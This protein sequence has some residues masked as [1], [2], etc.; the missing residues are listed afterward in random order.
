MTAGI[1]S[2]LDS[3]PHMPAGSAGVTAGSAT[4]AWQASIGNVAAGSLFALLQSFG[5]AGI[6]AAV[7]AV[8]G[9]GAGGLTAAGM[10]AHH[11]VQQGRRG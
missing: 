3:C 9:A 10:A 8:A 7:P 4:A 5:A 6:G 2:K 11:H 1:I